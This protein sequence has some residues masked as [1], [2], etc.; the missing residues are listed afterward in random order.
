[1]FYSQKN[2]FNLFS[3][4]FSFY[5]RLH[6]IIKKPYFRIKKKNLIAINK[7]LRKKNTTTPKNKETWILEPFL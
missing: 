7:I 4:F 6:V 1:M 5:N 2:A 3:F